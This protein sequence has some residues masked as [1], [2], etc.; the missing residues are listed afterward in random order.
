MKTKTKS[1]KEPR[2]RLF[3]SPPE[4]KNFAIRCFLNNRR[5]KTDKLTG[6]EAANFKV[7]AM[8]LINYLNNK[9]GVGV[10]SCSIDCADKKIIE[11]IAQTHKKLWDRAG[12]MSENGG[13]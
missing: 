2:H 6:S 11:E 12:R 1:K 5:K 7:A 13:S 8:H 3:K 10:V 9:Y 4:P